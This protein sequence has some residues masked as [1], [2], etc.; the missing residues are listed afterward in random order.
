MLYI[1][2]IVVMEVDIHL[3][4]AN[5]CDNLIFVLEFV[6]YLNQVDKFISPPKLV[7]LVC[8]EYFVCGCYSFVRPVTI[9]G[10]NPPQVDYIVSSNNYRQ[11]V[12][13]SRRHARVVYQAADNV[14]R[15]HDDSLNGVFVND[16]KIAGMH[17]RQD[18]NGLLCKLAKSC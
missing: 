16:I 4:S 8:C 6:S 3:T 18:I 5:S 14:H 2:L 1:I 10:R 11:N 13:V 15:I 7:H 9:I 17:M 12:V